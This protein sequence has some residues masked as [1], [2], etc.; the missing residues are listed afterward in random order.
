MWE[1]SGSGEECK[2]IDPDRDSRGTPGGSAEALSD[3][4]Q[5]RYAGYR[6]SVEAPRPGSEV[7]PT[8]EP[9]GCA[10][11]MRDP[12]KTSRRRLEDTIAPLVARRQ[13]E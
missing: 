9:C 7:R 11:L 10:A 12:G 2:Q 5:L 8:W 3:T 1:D 6:M 4:N 13:A